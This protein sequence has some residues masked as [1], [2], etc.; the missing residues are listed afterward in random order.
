MKTTSQWIKECLIK[1]NTVSEADEVDLD[2]SS[3]KKESSHSTCVGTLNK[4]P[5][6]FRW[7]HLSYTE[8]LYRLIDQGNPHVMYSE[9]ELR[10]VVQL[11]AGYNTK[12]LSELLNIEFTE[13]SLEH[14]CFF[15]RIYVKTF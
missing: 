1:E 9:H 10:P 14:P 4:V 5:C 7:K 3:I 15:G 13:S 2:L 8:I 11:P 12:D 6:T